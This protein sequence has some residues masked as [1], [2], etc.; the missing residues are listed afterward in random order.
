MGNQPRFARV[1]CFV[2]NPIKF[3]S[4]WESLLGLRR[5]M[6]HEFAAYTESE[7][8]GMILAFANHGIGEGNYGDDPTLRQGSGN[9]EI[10]VEV[11]DVQAWHDKA[12]S[13]GFTSVQAPEKKD[14]G[15]TV[16]YL[17]DPAGIRLALESPAED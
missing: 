14:W 3:A 13:L 4:M 16:A 17:K 15:Q 2:N 8:G 11:D 1:T 5:R 12:V 6:T 7:G 9:V 10:S